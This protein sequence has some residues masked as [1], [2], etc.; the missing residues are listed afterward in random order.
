MTAAEKMASNIAVAMNGGEWKDG[1]WYSEGHRKAWIEAVQP[2]ADEIER[3]REA[4]AVIYKAADTERGENDEYWWVDN[5]TTVQSYI[6]SVL[7]APPE[8]AL[9]EG[10]E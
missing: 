1:K 3:L 4:L 6:C 2:Y 8:D 10:K 5:Q 9:G 7:G